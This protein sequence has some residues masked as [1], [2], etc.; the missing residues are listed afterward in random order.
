MSSV[1]RYTKC[2]RC[3][4][5]RLGTRSICDACSKPLTKHEH[6]VMQTNEVEHNYVPYTK[7]S[8]SSTVRAFTGFTLIITC[9]WALAWVLFA[10]MG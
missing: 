4:R 9:V 10:I 8:L 7:H 5:L 1:Q 3:N 2:M 6:H